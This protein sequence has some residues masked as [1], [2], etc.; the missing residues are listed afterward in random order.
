MDIDPEFI[1]SKEAVLIAVCFSTLATIISIGHVTRHIL[2]YTMPGIQ[3][4][5]IR[6]L[7]IVPVYAIT[8]AL[9]LSLGHDGMYAER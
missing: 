1:W 9:A 7:L 8:S 4:Y 2:Y 6:I 3:V 5:V